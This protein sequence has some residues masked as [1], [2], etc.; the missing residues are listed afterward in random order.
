MNH[1]SNSRQACEA[2]ELRFQSL[3]DTGTALAFPCT[4]QGED[5]LNSLSVAARRNYLFARAVVGR[6]FEW[7]AVRPVTLH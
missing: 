3:Y 4:T 1:P 2:F 7:P 6:M 5:D